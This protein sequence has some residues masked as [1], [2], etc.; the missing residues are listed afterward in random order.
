ML[1]LKPLTITFEPVPQATS[2]RALYCF[3]EFLMHSI[4]KKNTEVEEDNNN[5]NSIKKH[6]RNKLAFLRMLRDLCVTPSLVNG[7]IGC[8]SQLDTLNRW[9]K[10]YNRQLNENRWLNEPSSPSAVETISRNPV[11]SCDEAIRFLSQVEDVARTESDYVTDL[12]LGGGAGIS[13]RDRA[14]LESPKEVCER[15]KARVK[16]LKAMCEEARK[17]RAKARW[18]RALEGV[19]TGKLSTR[20]YQDVTPCFRSLW[21]SRSSVRTSKDRQH[22]HSLLRRGWRPT[23]RFFGVAESQLVDRVAALQGLHKRQ[24]NFLWAHPF[25]LLF[26]NIP[27]Q[28][29]K[30]DLY[31]TLSACLKENDGMVSSKSNIFAIG[32]RKSSGNWKAIVHLDGQDTLDFLIKKAKGVR[33]IKMFCREE[34]PSIEQEI[35]LANVNLKEALAANSVHPCPMNAQMVASAKK[36]YKEAKMGLRI[37]SKGLHQDRYAVL[38]VRAFGAIRSVS[39]QLSESFYQSTRLQVQEATETL[40]TSMITIVREEALVKR[41]ETRLQGLAE[42]VSLNTFEALQALKAGEGHIENTVCPICYDHLGQSEGSNGKVYMTR[43]GHLSCFSCLDQWMNQKEQQREQLSCIE[44][45]KPVVRPQLV[46]VD[47]GK[48]DDESLERRQK[49][50]KSMVRVAAEMLAKNNGKLEP[51]LWEALY[52]AMDLPTNADQ[53]GHGIF[54]AIPGRLLA[55]L[56]NATGMSI[57]CTRKQSAG[58]LS[59]KVQALLADLP[60]DELSVVFASSKATIVHLLEVLKQENIGCR[61]LFTGQSEKDSERAVAAWK[62]DSDVLVLVVQAGAAACGLTLTAASKMFLMEPFI[63]HEEEKQAYARLHRY[64]QRRPVDCK[65]YFAPV[66]VESRL[67][68]WRRLTMNH[69]AEEEKTVYAPLRDVCDLDDDLEEEDTDAE[70]NQ[71]R[72]LLA[73]GTDNEIEN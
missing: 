40:K 36:R 52:L 48:K 63:K 29:T 41:L 19:T 38:L 3:L 44:C 15:A 43:C 55:H 54:T 28:V 73:L 58:R 24:P 33:G 53:S 25:A 57:H 14:F 35:E 62:S 32:D 23:A 22:V 72:F 31:N 27:A 7:G 20:E 67:L 70:E 47:P 18:L 16:E 51:H 64:G 9:M 5:S 59:S 60:K 50:A 45:R 26:S 34:I 4:L 21:K 71:T 42:Q 66:S 46:C 56:R 10:E 8:N 11:Y 12:R 17:K 68:E 65:V 69:K 1:P 6:Q 13:R 61:G 2:E 30:D 49:E 39:P 37:C